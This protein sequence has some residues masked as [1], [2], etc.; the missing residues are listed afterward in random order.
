MTHAHPQTISPFPHHAAPVKNRPRLSMLFLL[1]PLALGGCGLFGGHANTGAHSK[2]DKETILPPAGTLYANG[3]AYLHK[4]ED[5]K[6]SDAFNQVEVNYPYSTWA[7]HAELLHGYA[8]FRQQNFDSAVG[9]LNRFIELHPASPDAA[10]AYYLRALCYYEQIEGVHHDQTF[11]L[12]AVQAL[13]DVVTRF[14]NSAYARD[15]RVKLRLAQNRLA[16]HEMGI[17][18]FYERQNL[19]AAAITRYQV[20][21]QQY[22]TTTFVP[23]ALERLVECYLDLGLT[24]EAVRTAAVLG[25]NYPGSHWYQ[26]AYNKLSD[27][28]LLN[29]VAKPRKSGGFLF[30][31]L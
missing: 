12:E 13:Q 17:G 26:D 8:E 6:A 22:Q 23:E 1:V 15:S 5:K 30:G 19:Y 24:H 31:L 11:T 21:V 18:R 9:A 2:A 10:Y 7:T 3:I 27:H 14:P 28:H 25:Y 4:G 29:G 20:V 16:G